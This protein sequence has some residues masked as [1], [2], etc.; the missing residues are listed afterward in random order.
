[1]VTTEID[2]E[3]A[4]HYQRESEKKYIWSLFTKNTKPLNYPHKRE[5]RVRAHL[6]RADIRLLT[7]RNKIK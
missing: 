4:C 1:M 6:T 2:C 3:N 7:L 5:K